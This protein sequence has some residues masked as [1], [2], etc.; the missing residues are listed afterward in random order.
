MGTFPPM[1]HNETTIDLLKSTRKLYNSITVD[2]KN[3]EVIGWEHRV[4]NKT[5]MT[6]CGISEANLLLKQDLKRIDKQLSSLLTINVNQN[7]YNAIVSLVYSIGIS[8]FKYS[9]LL[10]TINSGDFIKASGTFRQWGKTNG[11]SH[12]YSVKLRKKEIELFNS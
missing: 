11:E 5:N 12:Y 6:Y 9:E 8:K 1:K 2:F 10:R 4:T 7:Q 3:A